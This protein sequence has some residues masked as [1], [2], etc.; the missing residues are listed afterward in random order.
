MYIKVSKILMS[1]ETFFVWSYRAPRGPSLLPPEKEKKI[2]I[3]ARL[4]GKHLIYEFQNFSGTSW[5]NI[6]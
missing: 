3:G 6:W 5:F 4:P 2:K 1:L